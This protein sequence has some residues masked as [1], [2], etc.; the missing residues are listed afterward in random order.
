MLLPAIGASAADPTLS[1]VASCNEEAAARTTGAAFP[2]PD[3]TPLPAAPGSP[4]VEGERDLPTQAGATE[5]SDPTGSIVT[6][7]ADPLLEGMDAQ[8]AHDPAYRAAYRECMHQRAG[9]PR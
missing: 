6:H 7:S 3:H 2:R 9:R 1:D 5:K 4:I 8:R